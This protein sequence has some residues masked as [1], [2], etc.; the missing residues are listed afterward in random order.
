MIWDWRE[1]FAALG[2]F[3][4]FFSVAGIIMAVIVVATNGF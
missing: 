2:R 3:I 1:A 4:Y